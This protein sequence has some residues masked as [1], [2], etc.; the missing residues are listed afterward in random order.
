M[1]LEV[2]ISGIVAAVE[3]VPISSRP[4][5]M[6]GCQAIA[7]PIEDEASQQADPAA[8]MEGHSSGVLRHNTETVLSPPF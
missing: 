8:S 7:T 1:L 5:R 2:C 6:A 3:F 4:I